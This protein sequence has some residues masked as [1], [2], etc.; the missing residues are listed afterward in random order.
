MI[1]ST[2]HALLAIASTVMLALALAPITV[3]VALAVLAYRVCRQPSHSN[4][5]VYASS[6]AW[7]LL[8]E[9]TAMGRPRGWEPRTQQ[10]WSRNSP[11]WLPHFLVGLPVHRGSD[12]LILESFKPDA[13]DDAT[14]WRVVLHM[15]FIGRAQRGDGYT[16]VPPG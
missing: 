5:W 2:I 7:V 10:R 12:E 6:R 9:W 3:S 8:R 4:C 11:W 13:P 1:R 16:S 15:L 14:G